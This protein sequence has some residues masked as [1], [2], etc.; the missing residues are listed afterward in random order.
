MAT[1]I[2]I[3]DRLDKPRLYTSQ[4]GKFIARQISYWNSANKKPNEYREVK[5]Q[6]T[7]AQ[8]QIA[9]EKLAR[10]RARSLRQLANFVRDVAKEAAKPMYAPRVLGQDFDEAVDELR[11]AAWKVSDIV[12][13]RDPKT[14]FA[15]ARKL[16]QAVIAHAF[17]PL[18][19]DEERR[20]DSSGKKKRNSQK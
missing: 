2:K 17:R 8:L 3:E 19:E 16:I 9:K 14:G 7:P 20:K 11:K 12:S 5:S 13:P 15:D 1:N 6:M 4:K 18:P 10:M